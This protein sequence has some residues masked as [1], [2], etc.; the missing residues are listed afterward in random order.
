VPRRHTN[1]RTERERAR[2]RLIVP[3]AIAVL[4]VWIASAVVGLYD[5][6]VRVFIATSALMSAV[7]GF[8]LG[9]RITRTPPDDDGSGRGREH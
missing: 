1:G 2:D 9:I 7:L 3:F 4:A 8:V 5:G 6:D